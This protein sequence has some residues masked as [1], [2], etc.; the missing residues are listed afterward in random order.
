MLSLYSGEECKSLE[1]ISTF[2]INDHYD[3]KIEI[4]AEELPCVENCLST[5][6]LNYW[7]SS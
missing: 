7:I 1:W 5:V 6:A 3:K 2:A 4:G